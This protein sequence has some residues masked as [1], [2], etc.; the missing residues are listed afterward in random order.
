[1][2][3]EHLFLQ[4]ELNKIPVKGLAQWLVCDTHLIATIRVTPPEGSDTDADTG[5]TSRINEAGGGREG[6][7]QHH[8]GTV[9]VQESWG[10]KWQGQGLGLPRWA[11]GG[12]QRA[13]SFW[14]QRSVFILCMAR[15]WKSRAFR[16]IGAHLLVIS[17]I[18]SMGFNQPYLSNNKRDQNTIGQKR[19]H[20]MC[21]CVC[22]WSWYE[23]YF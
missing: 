19:K 2:F 23:I 7:G 12:I 4:L 20:K 13:P 17:E 1:M 22:I 15:I 8:S 11:D 10:L 21:V 6:K 3:R 18:I 14:L 9:R 5:R 16:T